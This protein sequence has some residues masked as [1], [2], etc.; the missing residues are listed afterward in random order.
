MRG[1]KNRNY[2][3]FKHNRMAF[4]TVTITLA[5]DKTCTCRIEV[6]LHAWWMPKDDK[7]THCAFLPLCSSSKSRCVQY[8]AVR[9]LAVKANNGFDLQ[10][11]GSYITQKLFRK[12]MSL[13]NTHNHMLKGGV[14]VR[15]CWGFLV[16]Q[17][18]FNAFLLVVATLQSHVEASFCKVLSSCRTVGGSGKRMIE[19]EDGKIGHSCSLS[20]PNAPLPTPST[21]ANPNRTHLLSNPT[22]PTH[23]HTLLGV[24][25]APD[26]TF[27]MFIF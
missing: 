15:F 21:P 27:H 19:R 2:F 1:E 20:F 24:C 14:C 16:C 18:P 12:S 22:T 3:D 25:W 5:Q 9:L 17:E 4:R 11:V 8:V 23:T 6:Y 26:L 10:N 13:E 7:H